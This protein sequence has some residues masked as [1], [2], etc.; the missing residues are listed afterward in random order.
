[1]LKA[2]KQIHKS[3]TSSSHLFLSVPLR[4]PIA[5]YTSTGDETYVD[6]CRPEGNVKH[7]LF[8]VIL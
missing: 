5:A 4:R 6:A 3:N 2:Y 1:M 8:V 7:Q